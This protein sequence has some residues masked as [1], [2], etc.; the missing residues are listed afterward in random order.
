L[1]RSGSRSGLA[2]GCSSHF[3][4][5][6]EPLWDQGP[7]GQLYWDG[8]QVKACNMLSLGTPERWIVA[9]GAFGTFLV[10]LIRFVMGF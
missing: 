1:A 6:I 4:G 10:N 5:G 7:T 9:L 2:E 8:A 3:A